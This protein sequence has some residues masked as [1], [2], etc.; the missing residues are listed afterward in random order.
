[1]FIVV[2]VVSATLFSSCRGWVD[3]ALDGAIVGV[4]DNSPV[5]MTLTSEMYSWDNLALTSIPHFVTNVGH[6]YCCAIN[7]SYDL[8]AFSLYQTREFMPSSSQILQIGIT[9]Y[10]EPTPLVLHQHYTLTEP[11]DIGGGNMFRKRAA[12]IA[13]YDAKS[14]EQQ[15]GYFA[16]EGWFAIT[17]L[18]RVVDE[19]GTARY[20]MNAEFE[21]RVVDERG[22]VLIDIKHGKFDNTPI[23]V[24]GA[25]YLLK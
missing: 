11:V 25:E 15:F 8:S 22:N 21:F 2:A 12:T 16:N 13:C 23:R 6:D 14:G 3:D 7:C 10:Q 19:Q 20:K 1:M 18:E 4:Y 9:I 24:S 5:I 17:S